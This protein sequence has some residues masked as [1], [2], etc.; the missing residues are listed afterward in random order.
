M[1]GQSGNPSCSRYALGD[2]ST[3]VR[4][5]P[6]SKPPTPAT[7]HNRNCAASDATVLIT[8]DRLRRPTEQPIAIYGVKNLLRLDNS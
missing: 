7:K 2:K 6:Q 5:K 8:T 1:F 4:E 3:V